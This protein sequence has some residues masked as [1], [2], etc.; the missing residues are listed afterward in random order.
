MYEHI[1]ICK[2]ICIYL[3][4]CLSIHSYLMYVNDDSKEELH[5]K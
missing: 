1:N 4:V 3:F 2:C 5:D